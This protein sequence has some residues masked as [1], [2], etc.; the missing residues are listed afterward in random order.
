MARI[1]PADILPAPK[2]A[3][4][5]KRLRR[6]YAGPAIRVFKPSNST[7]LNI[8]FVGDDLD[9]TALDNFLTGSEI[10]RVVTVYDQMG[11]GLNL[12]QED[13]A[14]AP[15]IHHQ[16]EIGGARSL[17]FEGHNNSG[18]IFGMR[19][20]SVASLGLTGWKRRR[21]HGHASREFNS[22]QSSGYAGQVYRHARFAGGVR[23]LAVPR[24]Q[25]R[26]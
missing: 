23:R 14:K 19:A 18:A 25:Q 4:G 26:W 9:Y 20:A 15:K 5:V 21:G 11:T 7:Y 17:L 1:L 13:T 22:P 16:I 3:Y 6:A 12:E 24:L 2:V 10:G 8:G